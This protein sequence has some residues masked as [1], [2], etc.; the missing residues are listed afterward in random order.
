MDTRKPNNIDGVTRRK[1][2]VPVKTRSRKLK[3]EEPQHVPKLR[4]EK[5]CSTSYRTESRIDSTRRRKILRIV[6]PVVLGLIAAFIGINQFDSASVR[7]NPHRELVSVETTTTLTK[8]A[9][10]GELDFAV[11]AITDSVEIPLEADTTVPVEKYATGTIRIFNDYSTAPQRLSPKTRF[12]SVDGKIYMIGDDVELVIPGK[13]E[14]GPGEVTATVYASEPGEEYNIDVTDFSIPG[15]KELGLDEKYSTIY[16]LSTEPFTGGFTGTRPAVSEKVQET[17]EQQLTETLV[18][19]LQH[20][21]QVDKT[22]GMM[23]IENTTRIEREDIA[24]DTAQDGT[25]GTLSLSGTLYALLVSKE[26]LGTYLAQQELAITD[27]EKVFLDETST[28]SVAYQGG[29]IAYET[30]EELPVTIVGQGLFVWQPNAERIATELTGVAKSTIAP[31]ANTIRSI[32]AIN[33]KNHP[34]WRN[35]LPDAV[36]AITVKIIND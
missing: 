34:R 26:D 18:E 33:V 4:R 19:K 7:I 32:G 35:T 25:E 16:A 36:E 15:F 5:P 14:D 6:T 21:L 27:Q 1:R 29:D 22:F 24:F 23:V 11:I 30:V 10:I 31:I 28:V 17:H 2:T 12:E 8:S 13:T 20:R 9:E 3:V